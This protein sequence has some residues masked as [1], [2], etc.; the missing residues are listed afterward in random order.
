MVPRDVQARCRNAHATSKLCL[1][2]RNDVPRELFR[3]RVLGRRVIQDA[4]QEAWL[5]GLVQELNEK[6]ERHVVVGEI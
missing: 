5:Q 4:L 6:R 1:R 3:E 2:I